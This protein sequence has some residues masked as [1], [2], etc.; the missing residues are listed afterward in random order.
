MKTRNLA[1]I[2]SIYPFLIVMIFPILLFWE[3]FLKGKVLYWG[4]TSLQFLPWLTFTWRT[5]LQGQIPLWNPFNGMGSPFIANYQSAFFYPPIWITFPFY[6]LGGIR[7]LSWGLSLFVLSHIIWAGVGMVLLVRRFRFPPL[8]QVISGLSFACSSYLLARVNFVSMVCAIAWF[9]WLIWATEYATTPA[10]RKTF[11]KKVIQ[12]SPLILCITMQLLTGHAQIAWYCLIFTSIWIF[13]RGWRSTGFS[14]AMS[15]L[16]FFVSCSIAA[17][18]L[19]SIQILPTL[20]LL[21]NSQ[22]AS[23]VGYEYATNYSLWPWRLFT[24]LV[25]NIFGNPGNGTYWGYGNFWEDAIY[26]GFLPFVLAFFTLKKIFHKSENSGVIILLWCVAIISIFLA[27]G[28]N[29]PLF[30]FLYKFI[31]TFNLFQAPARFMIWATLSLAILAG[32]GVSEWERAKGWNLYLLRLLTM[33]SFAIMLAGATALFLVKGRVITI[34]FSVSLMG[35]LGVIT[36]IILLWRNGRIDGSGKIDFSLL[37]IILFIGI[38]LVY[39]NIQTIP[40][41][42][43]RESSS[44]SIT[45]IVYG[46][47]TYRTY[48]DKNTIYNLYYSRFFR[49]DDFRFLENSANIY[50]AGLPNINLV[51]RTSSANNFDPLLP[52]RYANWIDLLDNSD[53]NTKLTLLAFMDVNY[54]IKINPE[55]IAG[56]SETTINNPNRVHWFACAVSAEDEEESFEIVNE[57]LRTNS[58]RITHEIVIES[59]QRIENMNCSPNNTASFS[60]IKDQDNELE[61]VG[62]NNLPGWLLVADIYYPGWEVI[63]DGKSQE[64]F[65]AQYAFRAID[66]RPGKHDIIFT[67]RPGIFRIGLIISSF[68]LIV[69]FSLYIA[70]R[71]ISSMEHIL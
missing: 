45:P 6:I 71:K 52:K 17:F 42:S 38:D 53:L 27:L 19:A 55:N 32:F 34:A 66:L 36:G 33:G 24:F 8:S 48:F 13:T 51:N 3:L 9:P 11:W 70:A 68:S 67:Y 41:G 21:I 50:A 62:E 63:V 20:E 31:P 10:D 64:I 23:A 26:F 12:C 44:A 46:S 37:V 7:A 15:D 56:F 25:P 60:I 61:I 39:T 49:F 47:N 18:M 40:F 69:M 14:G 43:Y 16:L 57:W 2:K 29:F 59:N 35:L 22:R 65:P 28:K 4:T 5:L 54:F 30:P 58:E 1:R